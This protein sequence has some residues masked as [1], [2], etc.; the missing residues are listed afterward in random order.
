MSRSEGF[1]VFSLFEFAE[2]L[3]IRRAPEAVII[4]AK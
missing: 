4:M 1:D 3:A 2:G